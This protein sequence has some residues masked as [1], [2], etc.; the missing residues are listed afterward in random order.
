MSDISS[1]QKWIRFLA[2]LKLGD[3]V[4]VGREKRETK[5]REID[6]NVMYTE[7]PATDCTNEWSVKWR[8]GDFKRGLVSLPTPKPAH[9]DLVAVVRHGDYVTVLRRAVSPDWRI[10]GRWYSVEGQLTSSATEN[11]EKD[12]EAWDAGWRPEGDKS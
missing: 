6:C 5:L 10:C 12:V 1:D 3:R 4:I 7:D 11:Y 8:V 9:N 2:S